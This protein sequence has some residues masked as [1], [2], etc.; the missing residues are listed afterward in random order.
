MSMR[1]STVLVPSLIALALGGCNQESANAQ[2][3]AETAHSGPTMNFHRINAELA[4]G[5]HIVG[6]GITELVGQSVTLVID[7]RD[8]PPEAYEAQLAEAGIE[9]VNVPVVWKEPTLDNFAEFSQVMSENQE[10]NILVQCQANY[11]ASA[12]TYAYR[13]TEGR[14]PEA[15][16]RKDMEVIWTPEGDWEA[17]IAEVTG[18]E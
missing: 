17:Y 7:L 4:T 11:R 15:E 16:A 2:S 1:F 12:M 5:G 14:V 6:D 8:E 9:W 18:L 13:V 10:E 3:E